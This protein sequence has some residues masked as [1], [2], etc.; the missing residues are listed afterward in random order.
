MDFLEILHLLLFKFNMKY[1]NAITLIRHC[2]K[3]HKIPLLE[4]SIIVL[5]DLDDLIDK[6]YLD[7]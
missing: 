6:I 4:N 7:I 5:K 2:K 3:H 1:D